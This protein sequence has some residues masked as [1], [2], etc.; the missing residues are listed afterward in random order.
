MFIRI[1]TVVSLNVLF[2]SYVLKSVN[3]ELDQVEFQ[4]NY[5][6]VQVAEKSFLAGCIKTK[7]DAVVCKIKTK[8]YKDDFSKFLRGL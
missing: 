4:V 8:K 2:L 7:K 1:L 6:I 5:N 3:N